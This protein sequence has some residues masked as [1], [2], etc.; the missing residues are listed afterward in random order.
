VRKL[1]LFTGLVAAATLASPVAAF[2]AGGDKKPPVK[3]EGKVNDEGTKTAKNNKIDV[4]QDDFYFKPTY[5][6]AKKGTLTVELE[7]EGNA[8]HTFTIDSL[9]IDKELQPGKK[10]TVKVKVPSS[11]AVA[12]YCR[13]HK[14]QGMQGA[15]F[16]KAGASTT[17][18]ASNTGGT[19]TSR[20][21]ST[22]SG[23]SG[24]SYGY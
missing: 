24:G 20:A 3:L 17:S 5:I 13:F 16:T 14:G 8:P 21:P 12:F 2:A 22:T 15:I 23:S 1:A 4:E 18:S 6:K 9:D 11:S 7:N 10:A 19:P